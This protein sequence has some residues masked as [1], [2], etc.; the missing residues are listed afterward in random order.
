M[1]V[2]S[3]FSRTGAALVP[4]VMLEDLRYC[5]SRLQLFFKASLALSHG[6]PPEPRY[7]PPPGHD[8]EEDCSF[9]PRNVADTL[10]DLARIF[11]KIGGN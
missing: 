3:S 2:H 4:T 7:G 5:L 10:Q 9:N 8:M 11:G 6:V 1:A